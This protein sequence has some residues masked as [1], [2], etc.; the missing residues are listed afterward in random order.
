MVGIFKQPAFGPV[1]ITENGLVGDTP[2]A[3]RDREAEERR[4]QEVVARG[5]RA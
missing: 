5:S 4:L 3:V 1:E 2:I